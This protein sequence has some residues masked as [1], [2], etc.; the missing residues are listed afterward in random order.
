MSRSDFE[1]A[2]K[3]LLRAIESGGDAQVYYQY[4]LGTIQEG[5]FEG[6]IEYLDQAITLDEEIGDA[7]YYRA[8]CR[9]TAGKYEEALK[10]LKNAEN[11]AEDPEIKS[12]ITRLISELTGV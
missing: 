11:R 1:T 3:W 2:K 4:A 5:D 7:Y 9:L 10:D 8:I 12:E 6:A